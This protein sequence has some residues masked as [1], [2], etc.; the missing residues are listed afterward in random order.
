MGYVVLIW[1]DVCSIIGNKESLL[2]ISAIVSHIII[3]Y[4]LFIVIVLYVFLV[5][6]HCGKASL[7]V[8]ITAVFGS[9]L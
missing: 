9:E 5:H 7:L 4:M 1:C 2:F 3:T 8:R 6:S